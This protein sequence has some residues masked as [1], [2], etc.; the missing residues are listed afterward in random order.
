MAYTVI[1]NPFKLDEPNDPSVIPLKNNGAQWRH[2]TVFNGHK[3]MVL[4]DNIGGIISAH[5]SS[6]EEADFGRKEAIRNHLLEETIKAFNH[7]VS[8]EPDLTNEQRAQLLAPVP[9]GEGDREEAIWDS[10]LPI[11]VNVGNYSSPDIK[12]EG[13]PLPQGETVMYLDSLTEDRL[14]QA[15]AQCGVIFPFKQ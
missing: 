14:I 5:V 1:D 13:F 3:S 4:S 9:F 12:R 8:Q 7:S 6:Y 2:F 10:K 15:M 11:A